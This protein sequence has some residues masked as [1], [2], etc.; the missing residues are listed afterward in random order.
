MEP[1]RQERRV[2]VATRGRQAGITAIGFLVLAGLFGLVGLAGLRIVPLYLQ[3]MRVQTVLKDLGRDYEGGSGT[4]QAIRVE[5][6]KRFD[7]E[8]IEIPRDNVKIS[9]VKNG[10][11]VQIK[12]EARAPFIADIWFMV[13]LD[14]QVEIKR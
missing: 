5:L 4:P 7:I 14:E 10:Y 1:N 3:K 11:Q 2:T 13:M 9:Q 8:G 6:E 12:Q